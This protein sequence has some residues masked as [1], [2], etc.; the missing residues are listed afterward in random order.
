MGAVK[1]NNIAR[2]NVIMDEIKK[3]DEKAYKRLMGKN[4]LHWAKITF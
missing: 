4:P 1:A 2:F 3:E